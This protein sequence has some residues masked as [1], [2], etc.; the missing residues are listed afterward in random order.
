MSPKQ[1]GGPYWVSR[2]GRRCGCTVANTSGNFATPNCDLTRR[3]RLLEVGE[4]GTVR[5]LGKAEK[6]NETYISRALW[7]TLLAP[8]IVEAILDGRQPE[9]MTLPVLMEGVAVEWP[10]PR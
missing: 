9:G 3:R 8:K 10:V 1:C 6:V 2:L 7:L 5:E 4:H